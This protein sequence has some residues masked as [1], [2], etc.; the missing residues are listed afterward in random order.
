MK[1][2]FLFLSFL[3]CS[4]FA[5]A[6]E[7]AADPQLTSR[8]NEYMKL[9]KD[10]DID[11]LLEYMHPNIFKVVP[12]ATLSETMKGFYTNEDIGISIDSVGV[13]NLGT[14]FVSNKSNYR[15]VRYKMVMSMW[16]KKPEM[17]ASSEAKDAVL[18]SLQAGFPDKSVIY[19]E[20]TSKFV[21]RGE[22]LV[23]AIQDPGQPWLFLGYEKSQAALIS[24]VFPKEVIDHYKL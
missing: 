12:K 17:A 13:S 1:N 24:Q 11:K 23:I 2:L 6:Q 10:M 18:Q 14:P 3:F 22:S 9:S 19:D 20:K 15:D 21:I 5:T 16:L 7:K 8:L 4:F